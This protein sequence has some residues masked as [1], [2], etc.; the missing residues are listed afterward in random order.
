[1]GGPIFSR[2]LLAQE[3][4]ELDALLGHPA[5]AVTKRATII[6]LSSEERYRASEISDLVGM[7]ASS[8]RYWIRRFNKEGMIA[9]R[10]RKARG[11]GSRV[12]P[13]ARAMLIQLAATPPREIGLKFTTWTL[14]ELKEHLVERGIV[15][16][17]SHETIRRILKDNNIDWRASGSLPKDTPPLNLLESS[18]TP[19]LL[20]E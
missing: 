5:D 14:R 15:E 10:P 8:V 13:D 6:L 17:I 11:W 4:D 1:M 16:E 20:E 9:V 12:N 18:K 3:R 2:K 19:E 7:H